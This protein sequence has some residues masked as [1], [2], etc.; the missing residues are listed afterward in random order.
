MAPN[1]WRGSGL[2]SLA[3]VLVA[4]AV[5]LS[6]AD[7]VVRVMMESP[8]EV[9]PTMPPAGSG[10]GTGGPSE[11]PPV[12][13]GPEP[14]RDCGALK[15]FSS[16]EELR[17]YLTPELSGPGNATLSG[18]PAS[19]AA[20]GALSYSTTNNQVEGVDEADIVKTDGQNLYVV[21][22]NSVVVLQAAPPEQAKVLAR[23]PATGRIV[24][25]FIHG[26]RLVVLE[27]SG[28]EWWYAWPYYPAGMSPPETWAEVYDVSVPSRPALMRNVSVD[29][30][31]VASRLSLDQLTLVVL[32]R[33]RMEGSTPVLPAIA[34]N[35]ERNELTYADVRHLN[36]TERPQ[37]IV[38]V[39]AIDLVRDLPPAFEAVF[40]ASASLVY[41][42]EKNV[43]VGEPYGG[44]YEP[45]ASTIHKFSVSRGRVG[46]L[47]SARVPGRI[48]NQFSMDEYKGYLRVATTLGHVALGGGDAE[49]NVFIVDETLSV[50]GR[51][52]G[53]APGE[54]IYSARFMGDRA[55][56]VTFKK[57]DPFFVI[58]LSDPF[59]PKVLGYLKIP[60]FSDYLHPYDETHVIGVGKDAHDM[61]DFAWYQGLKLSLFDVADVEHPTEV[62]K[63]VIGDRGTWSEALT[64]H[65]AFLFIPSR[66]LLVLPVHLFEID[67][68]AYPEGAPP[69][70]SGD[71]IWQGAYV[72]SVTL[73]RG[74]EVRARIA[75][76][77]TFGGAGWYET[78]PGPSDVRRSLYIG[79]FLYTISESRVKVN[80]LDTFQEVATVEM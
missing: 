39:L 76:A 43:Y 5:V 36:A 69:Y 23:V 3:I 50:V 27:R 60:G 64:D 19:P 34:V 68:T 28:H 21:S 49:N 63:I 74:F 57:I 41:A 16:A 73:E 44:S 26:S 20:G 54:Q 32:G 75:H 59:A 37:S 55:Y 42:S 40:A 17:A 56:L 24:G 35:G 78:F 66:K 51:L 47:C 52:E 80:S 29:G 48:L 46:Y 7:S 9:V 4:V 31:Y 18:R 79:D 38:I 62:A 67:R 15:A 72:L 6:V 1:S 33:A 8:G 25:L 65:K 30:L 11:P 77:Q 70:V 13:D 2:L 14:V 61:G 10:G 12:Q 53:L 58:D 71:F 22:N 45:S